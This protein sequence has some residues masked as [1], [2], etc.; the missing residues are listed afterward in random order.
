MACPSDQPMTSPAKTH[1]NG[2]WVDYGL[3]HSSTPLSSAIDDPPLEKRLFNSLHP[4]EPGLA[5]ATRN[6]ISRSRTWR[7]CTWPPRRGASSP[8]I[9]RTY[10]ALIHDEVPLNNELLDT[11]SAVAQGSA[12]RT[13]FCGGPILYHGQEA[14]QASPSFESSAK[15]RVDAAI[16]EVP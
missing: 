12:P 1:T 8:E 16:R 7:R 5:F 9:V 3:T 4:L 15:S 6:A 14:S 13:L 2:V 10:H 11:S